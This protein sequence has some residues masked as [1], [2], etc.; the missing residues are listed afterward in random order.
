MPIFEYSCEGCGTKFEKLIY[1][2]D[3]EAALACPECGKAHPRR[4]L[5]TF[6]AHSHGSASAD[7]P[8]CPSGGMCPTPGACG[9]N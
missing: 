8:R 6:A 2:Q 9:L 1:R 3:D 5:S 7:L 4:E